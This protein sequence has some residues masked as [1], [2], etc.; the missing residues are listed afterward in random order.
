MESY[1][2]QLIDSGLTAHQATIYELLIKNGGMRA[3]TIVRQL[4]SSLSRPMVYMVLDELVTLGLVE[5]NEVDTK[6]TRFFPV[7]PSKLHDIALERRA[8]ADAIAD[9]AAAVI[10]RIVSDYNLVSNKPGV[11]FFEGRQGV[12]VVLEDSLTAKTPIYSYTDVEQVE[13][14]YKDLVDPY[15]LEREKRK[16]MKKL[17]LD[18]TPF[19]RDLYK[20]AEE[21]QSEVRLISKSDH[22]YKVAIQIYDDKV[23]YL[24]LNPGKE[25]AIIIQD[26]EIALLQRHLFEELYNRATPLY[27]PSSASSPSVASDSTLA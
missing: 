17:L 20:G 7:H 10:P 3:S 6:V 15:L 23:S 26:P 2:K 14:Y 5:K 19:T 12:R 24:T 9:A 8:R 27:I 11:R 1:K 16:V 13:M 4:N 25:V 18:D 22:S 21:S